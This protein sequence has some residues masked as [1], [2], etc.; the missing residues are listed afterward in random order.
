MTNS[1]YLPLAKLTP[2]QRQAAEEGVLVTGSDRLRREYT[3]AYDHARMLAGDTAWR[4]PSIIG[5]DALLRRDYEH[6]RTQANQ[7]GAKHPEL[8]SAIRQHTLF[9]SLAPEGL[10]HLTKVFEEAWGLVH[11]WRIDFSSPAF[12]ASVNTR[13]F[14]Q[15]ASS[16]T[17]ALADMGAITSAQLADQRYPIQAVLQVNGDAPGKLHL[18]GFDVLTAAQ[19]SW[20][21]RARASGLEVNIYSP[22]FPPQSANTQ[23]RRTVE[24]F[25]SS[26]NELTAAI[27]WSRERLEEAPADAP[28]PRIAIVVPDLL[29]QHATVTRLLHAHLEGI[30]ERSQTLYN[31]GGG[32]PLS[33]HPLV[34]SALALLSCTHEPT[35]YTALQRLLVDPALPG[36]HAAN[37]LPEE[38][39]EFLTL[40]ELPQSVG[41]DALRSIIRQVK[42]FNSPPLRSVKDWWSNA[43]SILRN[44][45]WHTARND[46]EGFQATNALLDIL[47]TQA[48]DSPDVSWNE[49]YA[50]LVSVADQTLFAPAGTQAPIQVLGYLEA[51]ELEFDYLWIAGMDATSWPTPVANNPLLPA[52]ELLR[53]NAPRTTYADELAFAERW[54]ARVSSHPS[55]ICA[56]YVVDDLVTES[57]QTNL[58]APEENS[59]IG[60][61]ELPRAEIAGAID[62]VSPL[63]ADWPRAPERALPPQSHPLIG[64]WQAQ[65]VSLLRVDDT[66]G[67]APAAGTLPR[68]TRRLENQAACPMRGWGIFTLDL[69]QPIAPH[70][71]PNPL[72][73]GN[74]LHHALQE[75][76]LRIPSASA[77]ENTDERQREVICQDIADQRVEQELHRFAKTIRRIEAERLGMALSTFL[78][79]ESSRKNFVVNAREQEI[80]AQL[81]PWQVRLQIDRIDD[82]PDGQVVI[83]YKSSAP[84]ALKLL[85]ERLSAPQIPLYVL[86]LLAQNSTI[87]ALNVDDPVVQAGAFAELKPDSAKYVGLR[88]EHSEEGM[89]P[90]LNAKQPWR[91]TL[92]DWRARLLNLCSELERGEATPRPTK[93]AC[94]FCDLHSLCRYHLNY[95]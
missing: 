25:G 81:G 65:D 16:A 59:E 20:L 63:L 24:R 21:E 33:Q 42:S 55:E 94:D 91:Q 90:K 71:L 38:C 29:Q 85:D 8:L 28:P 31:M 47:I 69:E 5:F 1:A 22:E 74:L 87:D 49:A 19:K 18:T 89:P 36:I 46:S 62:G 15:W 7:S 86:F 40:A 83:D 48:P 30:D 67:T 56:S 70:S 43:A 35:H 60:G 84:S 73:R 93:G 52:S 88:A 2:A 75:L 44:A 26:T 39:A 45:R 3:Y 51:I 61:A 80:T 12:D 14:A 64:Y 82:V 11:A 66:T 50:L 54:L 6:A 57:E 77:L 23:R 34:E 92:I 13:S 95:D 4:E 58:N 41:P 37:R 10:Q 76:F 9:R 17:E 32:L 72:E 78:A 68:A 27:E 53:V 79:L